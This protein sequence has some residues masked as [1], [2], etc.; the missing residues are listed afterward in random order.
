MLTT[1]D[2]LERE[3]G[4][5]KLLA[6]ARDPGPSPQLRRLAQLLED[7]PV[8]AVFSHD[9]Y[10]EITAPGVDK[11]T[12]L[13]ALARHMGIPLADFAAVG[14]GHNDLGMFCVV[15]CP[16]AMGQAP[17]EVKEAAR[18]ITGS[19]RENGLASVLDT[20]ELTA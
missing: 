14:D 8:S 12:G 1:P 6:I 5:H 19:N 3:P 10:L 18:W 4:P 20:I 13:E 17:A 9:N 2:F 15:G 16:V 7:V 11:A